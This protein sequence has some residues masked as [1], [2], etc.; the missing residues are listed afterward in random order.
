MLPFI[1]RPL[2][3]A[4]YYDREDIRVESLEEPEIG[5]GELLVRV[6]ASGIC[7]TDLVKILNR[8][9]RPPA[10]L[11]HEIAGEVIK[12]GPQVKSFKVGDRVVVA[13]HVP[14]YNCHYCRHQN[15]AMCRFY[16]ASNVDPGGFSEYI[17]VPELH[18]SH[19][20]F[21]IPPQLSYD[22]AIFM[23]PLACCLKSIRRCNFQ[24][25]DTAV[26]VGLGPMG[27][28]MVQLINLFHARVL[29]VD[30]LDSRLELG[31]QL[32]AARVV[33]AQPEA[34]KQAAMEFSEGRGVDAVILTAGTGETLV[35][36]LE[37]VRDSG[38]I[39]SFASVP[40]GSL[41]P[42]DPNILYHREITLYGSYSSAPT[43]LAHALKYLE[44]GKVDVNP[45]IT[46][47]LPLERFPQAL[48]LLTEKKALKVIMVP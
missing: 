4:V 7:G 27:L 24:P 32:G 18:T 43:D 25:G 16:K 44:T 8:K 22:Q 11:G 30:L 28:M 47:R 12:A 23:E 6:K 45:L 14:C 46:H 20:T 17:R 31:L 15:Y 33:S 26:V 37:L 13:H 42:L 9:V 5:L 29:G 36:A 21:L 38:T 1:H 35:Q 39:N 19:T 3:A 34:V 40:P 48:Q 41:A 2:R 10:I